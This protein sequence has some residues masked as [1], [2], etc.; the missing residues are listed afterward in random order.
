[1]R[2]T[3]TQV[4]LEHENEGH[5]QCPEREDAEQTHLLLPRQL[6]LPQ[7]NGRKN[8]QG[9]IGGRVGDEN[10]HDV[11][12]FREAFA[13]HGVRCLDILYQIRALPE[14]CDG[15][16]LEDEGHDGCDGVDEGVDAQDVEGDFESAPIGGEDAAVEEEDGDFDEAEAGTVEKTDGIGGLSMVR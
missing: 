7:P 8:Q 9:N 1:M 12:V 3:P 10:R 14:E 13:L 2:T 16:T 4:T 15:E 5:V 6:Q 11:D